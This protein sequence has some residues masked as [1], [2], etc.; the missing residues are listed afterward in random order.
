[1]S[2]GK[3]RGKQFRDTTSEDAL[4]ARPGTTDPLLVAREGATDAQIAHALISLILPPFKT[5]A[6]ANSQR[7]LA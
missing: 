7:G 6:L 3:G 1:L 5:V 4:V 2:G